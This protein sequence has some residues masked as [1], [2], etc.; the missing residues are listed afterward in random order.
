MQCKYALVYSFLVDIFLL[1]N[2]SLQ[3]LWFQYREE[4]ISVHL[5]RLSYQTD[6]LQVGNL[7][8]LQDASAC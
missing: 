6:I 3:L 4:P 2:P 7:R 5:L 8:F 1:L